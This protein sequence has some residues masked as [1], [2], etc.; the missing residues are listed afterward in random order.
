MAEGYERLER[1]ARSDAERSDVAWDSLRLA[2]TADMKYALQVY[3]VEAAVPA[4]A[5]EQGAMQGIVDSFERTYAQRFGEGVGYPEGGIDLTA[6]RLGVQPAEPIAVPAGGG[7]LP[8]GGD[9]APTGSRD[10]YWTELKAVSATPV[11]TGPDLA[12]GT[13]IDGPALVDYPDTT[14]VLRPEL[15]LT[16]EAGG[17]LTIDLEA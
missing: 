12:A 6:L 10:V 8:T 17:N 2:R 16:V 3:D 4:G 9:S 7:A 15:R 13:R 5:M 1:L 14:V 11:Y